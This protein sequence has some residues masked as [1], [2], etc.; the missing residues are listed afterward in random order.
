M[1]TIKDF[2]NNYPSSKNTTTEMPDLS[3]FT[4]DRRASHVNKLKE[5]LI[6][7]QTVVGSD[8]YESGSIRANLEN[9]YSDAFPGSALDSSWTSSVDSNGSA[10]VASD[11]LRLVQVNGESTSYVT[12]SATR[13]YI[14]EV[15]FHIEHV[16]GI[17]SDA[18]AIVGVSG[19]ASNVVAGLQ[20][21]AGG[22]RVY[23]RR[24]G[25]AQ[26]NTGFLGQDYAWVR[27]VYTPTSFVVGYST[28]DSA[29]TPGEGDWT[30]LAREEMDFMMKVEEVRLSVAEFGSNDI[31]ADCR[32]FSVRYF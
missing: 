7:L 11:K 32:N 25:A 3:N 20:R 6:E 19:I 23:A 27:L 22:V 24:T 17:D 15:T 5:F 31:T 18:R 26:V 13:G 14:V 1:G 16:S 12:R 10:T 9:S 2:S 8:S 29:T 21:V 30:F 4:D 28:N